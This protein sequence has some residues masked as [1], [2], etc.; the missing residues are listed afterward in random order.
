MFCSLPIPDRSRPFPTPRL[1]PA[2]W[3]SADGTPLYT[4]KKRAQKWARAEDERTANASCSC[5]STPHP[6]VA[7]STAMP[8]S[9]P[10]PAITAGSKR[11]STPQTPR[12]RSP[13]QKCTEEGGR[14]Q[15]TP[16]L[17]SGGPYP[18][19]APPGT[20]TCSCVGLR[21]LLV[22]AHGGGGLP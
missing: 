18:N 15:A 11:G 1:A 5:T 12:V 16:P 22:E 4:R 19:P 6:R 14:I 2:I 21:P 10:A 7:T 9:A 3:A 20:P 8:S 13:H 17:D